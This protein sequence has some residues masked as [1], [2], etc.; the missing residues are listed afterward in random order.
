[1]RAE[2]AS[3]SSRDGTRMSSFP[4]RPAVSRS[5]RRALVFT[6][7]RLIPSITFTA[8]ASAFAES[9]ESTAALGDAIC[10]LYATQGWDLY[11]EFY[12]NDAGVQI[13]TLAA[14]TQ[15]R[16][17]GLKP[18]DAGWHEAAYNGDYIADIAADFLAKKTV[19]ADDREFTASGKDRLG[20]EVKDRSFPPGTMVQGDSFWTQVKPVLFLRCG[21]DAPRCPPPARRNHQRPPS[22]GSFVFVTVISKI[23]LF[24]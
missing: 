13:A 9:A 6:S 19:K 11:R 24:S 14:S 4:F 17:K 2:S 18:G 21:S 5:L 3:V 8:C 22:G 16:I 20:R 23:G 7:V 12:Y 15:A 10:N 1:M